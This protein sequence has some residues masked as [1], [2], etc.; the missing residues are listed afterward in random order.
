MYKI[1]EC[2]SLVSSEGRL[3]QNG[4]ERERER[5]RERDTHTDIHVIK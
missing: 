3:F 1:L 5:E 4:L 2:V